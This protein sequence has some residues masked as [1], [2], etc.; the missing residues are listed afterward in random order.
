MIT[1]K[2]HIFYATF[3]FANKTVIRVLFKVLWRRANKQRYVK[4]SSF[5]IPRRIISIKICTDN[6]T[7]FLYIA[8]TNFRRNSRWVREIKAYI[9]DISTW[10]HQAAFLATDER[11]HQA[12]EGDWE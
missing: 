10:L 1:D 8:I 4:F 9:A 11:G 5:F 6:L 7:Q 12:G 3:C 2:K